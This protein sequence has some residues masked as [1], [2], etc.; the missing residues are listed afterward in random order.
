MTDTES[1]KQ[2]TILVAEDES[3]LRGILVDMIHQGGFLTVEA[4]DG[5]ESLDRAL[6]EHPDLILLN[7]LM[8]KMDGLSVLRKLS[9]DAWGANVPVIVLSNVDPDSRELEEMD[10]YKAAYY[11][12]KTKVSLED[13]MKKIREVLGV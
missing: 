11:L 1:P 13:I 3:T 4:A 6:R 10:T 8:P 2:R 12:I 7:I 9:E 5:Q